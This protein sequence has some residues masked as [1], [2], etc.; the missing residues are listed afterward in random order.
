MKYIPPDIAKMRN[1]LIHIVHHLIFL[2]DMGIKICIGN[3]LNEGQFYCGR[4]SI[5][6]VS[7]HLDLC[8]NSTFH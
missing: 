6:N 5:E 8:P 3:I 4:I 1:L 7:E 2:K